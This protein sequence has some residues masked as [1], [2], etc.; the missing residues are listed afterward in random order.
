[1]LKSTART[2]RELFG[3]QRVLSL[4]VISEGQPD[5][6]LLPFVPLAAYAGVLVHASRMSKHGAALAAGCAILGCTGASSGG[7]CW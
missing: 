6:G 4:A 1:M 2:P 7:S 3:G 5:A